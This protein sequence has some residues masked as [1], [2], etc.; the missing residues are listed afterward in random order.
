MFL[1]LKKKK[2]IP[3]YACDKSKFNTISG[4]VK[5]CGVVQLNIKIIN[6]Q[7]IVLALIV[8]S[9]TF[10]SAFLGGQ[11]VIKVFRLCHNEKPEIYQ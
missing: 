3:F 9:D 5:V 10:S 1:S 7:H 11:D 6:I 8:E 2:N 4:I